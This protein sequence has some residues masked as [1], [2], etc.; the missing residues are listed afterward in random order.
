MKTGA[1]EWRGAGNRSGGGGLTHRR[2]E[3]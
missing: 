2:F 1:Q 3:L